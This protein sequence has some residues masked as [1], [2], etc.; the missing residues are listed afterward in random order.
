MLH[1]HPVT[2]FD[3]PPLSPYR[4]MRWQKEQRDSG[5][6]VAEGEKVVHRLLESD[7][8]IVSLLLPPKWLEAYQGLIARHPE[9]IHAYTADKEVLEELT[10]FTMYQGVLGVAKVPKP[11]AIDEALHQLQRPLLLVAMDGITSAENVGGLI[12]G[13]VAFG[14]DAIV[15][16][17]TSCSPYL[18]RAVRGSMGSIFKL[19]VIES[20]NLVETLQ[21][22]RSREIRCIAA[23]PHTDRRVLSQADFSGDC[24]IVFGSEGLGISPEVL[25]TCDEAVAIPMQNE[26][27]SLNVSTAGAVFLYEVNRQRKKA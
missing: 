19:P 27:D 20:R 4:T 14:T 26:V 15:V 3:A 8:E 13:C 25:R 5:I 22:F 11:I 6:F 12:R 17:E 24:C 1:V 2:D 23:H 21:I 9:E 7:L 10:G 16:G 18:R